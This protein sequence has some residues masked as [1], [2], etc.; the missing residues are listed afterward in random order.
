MSAKSVHSRKGLPSSAAFFI[1]L[2]LAAGC[3]GLLYFGLQAL[4]PQI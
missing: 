3:I 4:L 1:E 2:A